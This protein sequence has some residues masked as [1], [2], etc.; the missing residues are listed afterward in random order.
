MILSL[1]TE[2]TNILQQRTIRHLRE[3]FQGT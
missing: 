2:P 1:F 3:S